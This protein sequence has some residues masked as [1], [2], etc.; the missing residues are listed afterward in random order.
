[1]ACPVVPTQTFSSAV[2]GTPTDFVIMEFVDQ[3]MVIATQVGRLG[4]LI[5]ARQDQHTRTYFI[6]TLLGRRDDPLLEI[7][8]RQLIEKLSLTGSTKDVMLWLGL[9]QV[10]SKASI[11]GIIQEVARHKPWGEPVMQ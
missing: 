7:C 2:D 5:Q 1:M 8:G 6:E 9:S 11:Q 10:S 3:V 4:T